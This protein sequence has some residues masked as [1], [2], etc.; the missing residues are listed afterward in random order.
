V[1][2]TA[3]GKE[4][5]R[6]KGLAGGTAA[7]AYSRDGKLLASRGGDGIIRIFDAVKGSPMKEIQ[8]P[9]AAPVNPGG[10]FVLNT[11]GPGRG[12]TLVFSPD[13]QRIAAH[14]PGMAFGGRN[15]A[16]VPAGPLGDSLLVF[17][18]GTGKEVRKVTLPTG[19]T[20]QQIAFSPDARLIASE[21]SDQTIS[22]W[23]LASGKER[24]R[25]GK[26]GAPVAQPAQ[27]G[28]MVVGGGVIGLGGPQQVS[29][30]RSLEF[31]PDGS[32]LAAR[33]PSNAVRVFEVR[34][35]KE[36]GQFTGHEGAVAAVAFTP[37]G[38]AVA[39]ASRDTTALVWDVAGLKR[40][41]AANRI[42][43]TAKERDALWNELSG[44]DAG[45]AF[46]SSLRLAAAPKDTVAFLS[47]RLQPAT[48][49]DPAKL[50]KLVAD[51]GSDNFQ[52]RTK[53]TV[54]LEALRDLAVPALQKVLASSPPLETKRRI[55]PILDKITTGVLT[56]D[57]V[58]LV[59]AVEVLEQIGSP[60]ARQVLQ[61]LASGAA[62]ALS[63][64][65]AQIVL[66]RL[67]R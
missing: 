52:T 20:I 28:W 43:L 51:L 38:K 32:L 19:L 66:Q 13:G 35:G 21:N 64:R 3:G 31:S 59:R 26:V 22:L 39:S 54:E 30:A 61:T 29:A 6:L 4:V 50:D 24:Q 63:T 42:E 56:S 1:R 46:Q 45:K 44:D 48:P 49:V 55:E 67:A 47:D 7:L 40:E 11:G 10:G 9:G 5:H 62:G 18:V 15:P 65:Q 25:L 23:E 37:D 16:P 34:P 41:P 8:L 33:G 14:V 2:E 53:A 57:Q 58:R 27:G 17:D 36:I 12:L 60:E